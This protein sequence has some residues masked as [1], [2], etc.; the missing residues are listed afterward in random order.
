MP[1]KI[2]AKG[3]KTKAKTVSNVPKE[4]PKK[5]KKK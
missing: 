1:V 3:K 4:Q 5:K 2:M